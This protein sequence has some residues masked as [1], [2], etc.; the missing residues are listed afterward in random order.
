[1]TTNVCYLEHAGT[2]YPIEITAFH[3]APE[4]VKDFWIEETNYLLPDNTLVVWLKYEDRY[5][6]A[7][8]LHELR[9]EFM[10]ITGQVTPTWEPF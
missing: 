8:Y 9:H 6:A 2:R 1:M 10:A 4:E 7:Q 3:R 5:V